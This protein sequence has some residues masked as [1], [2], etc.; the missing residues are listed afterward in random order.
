MEYVYRSSF[1]RTLKQR[2]RTELVEKLCAA[3]ELERETKLEARKRRVRRRSRKE[4]KKGKRA[5]VNQQFTIK[6]SLKS[7]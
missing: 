5:P 6:L 4:E 7:V 1:T 3:Y 2:D